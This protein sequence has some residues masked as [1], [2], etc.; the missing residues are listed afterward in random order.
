MPVLGRRQ[1]DDTRPTP[2][3][4]GRQPGLSP[5]ISLLKCTDRCDASL[6]GSMKFPWAPAPGRCIP[7]LLHELIGK[8]WRMPAPAK[9]RA[10]GRREQAGRRSARICDFCR[11][12]HIGIAVLAFGISQALWSPLGDS[13]MFGGLFGGYM[14]M[15]RFQASYRCYPVSFIDR[16]EAEKGD[17]VFLPPSALDRLCECEPAHLLGLQGLG[18]GLEGR[19]GLGEEPCS[20][21]P[22]CAPRP[23]KKTKHATP[24]LRSSTAHRLPHA[25]PCG[26]PADAAVHALRRAGV[27]G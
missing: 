21:R 23:M 10:L 16:T 3:I 7:G 26:E 6:L 14:P 24:P 11:L 2:A 12:G 17:K 4:H 15:G 9:S 25:L 13:A 27:C 20:P 8:S 1:P 18:Q 22:S 19:R 5:P